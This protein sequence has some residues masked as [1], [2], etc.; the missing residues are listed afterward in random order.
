MPYP[1]YA[2]TQN[3]QPAVHYLYTQPQPQYGQ[4]PPQQQPQQQM[5]Y[6]SAPPLGHQQTAYRPVPTGYASNNHYP[7]QQIPPSNFQYAS[8]PQPYMA[9]APVGYQPQQQPQQ[10]TAQPYVQQQQPYSYTPQMQQQPV[11][12]GYAQNPAVQN[13][14][15]SFFPQ[16]G[17]PYAA[18]PPGAVPSMQRATTYAGPGN[19]NSPS[20][21]GMAAQS[22]YGTLPSGGNYGGAYGQA[23]AYNSVPLSRTTSYPASP[24]SA[25]F[26]NTFYQNP[27]QPQPNFSSN[28]STNSTISGAAPPVPATPVNLPPL[29]RFPSM[30]ELPD[31][32]EK[33]WTEKEAEDICNRLNIVTRGVLQESS[34]IALTNTCAGLSPSQMRDV[35]E[36]YKRTYGA[37]LAE[38]I[39]GCDSS[40]IV[41]AC[42]ACA[43]A[44][45][46]ADAIGMY[47]SLKGLGLDYDAIY[48]VMIGRKNEDLAAIRAAYLKLFDRDLDKV[49]SERMK[50]TVYKVFKALVQG[51][52]KEGGQPEDPVKLAESLRSLCKPATG[53]AFAHMLAV[54][55]LE[56][57]RR[58][59]DA[60]NSSTSLDKTIIKEFPS[61]IEKSLL[62]MVS[63]IRDPVNHLSQHLSSALSGLVTNQA[64]L[65][66]LAVR[67]RRTALLQAAIQDYDKK[68]S[69]KKSSDFKTK[70]TKA[71]SGHVLRFLKIAFGLEKV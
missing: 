61:D 26:N 36:T 40:L 13:A 71:A 22:P 9:Q 39:G 37:K 59:F 58:A 14:R 52:R 29:R 60:W 28:A 6:G 54:H 11:M 46:E 32:Q 41:T 12:G 5:Y 62:A 66:R 43:S 51:E 24:Q 55:S 30:E 33:E 21:D 57:L 16:P 38:V 68:A 67:Y 70:V 25:T 69:A 42:T 15:G 63:A 50:G 48:E 23:G 7:Q 19:A 64:K 47:E 35:V 44:P 4:Q 49:L 2:N 3:G 18:T 45:G 1:G 10:Y 31:S 53:E 17:S 8:G 34:I 65:L 56:S 20:S 27:Q